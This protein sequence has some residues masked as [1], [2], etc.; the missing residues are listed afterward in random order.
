SRSS[1]IPLLATGRSSETPRVTVTFV[2][3][4]A[5]AIAARRE[6]L[7]RVHRL[8]PVFTPT[9]PREELARWQQ[10]RE[11]RPRTMLWSGSVDGRA[12]VI[13]AY[14]RRYEREGVPELL[15]LLARGIVLGD[16]ER[17]T[18]Q[19]HLCVPEAIAFDEVNDELL[20]AFPQ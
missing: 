15:P 18:D 4:I 6:E 9:V 19:T 7:R 11:E 20:L 13:K 5:A 12:R 3:T 16:D 10:Q 17:L 14:G 1:S 8:R 2:E